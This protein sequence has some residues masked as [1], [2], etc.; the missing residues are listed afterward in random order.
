[1]PRRAA[2][3][4]LLLFV[5]SKSIAQN[6]R[7]DQI[8]IQPKRDVNLSSLRRFQA[9]VGSEVTRTF[10]KFGRL[11]IV[12]VPKGEAA[13]G[14]VE[15]YRRSG[16]VEFAEPDFFGHVFLTP[17]DPK[18]VDH[19][20][21]G[22]DKISAPAAWD[23]QNTASNII[24]AVVD[25]GVRYTHE[26][27]AANMW[28]NPNDGSHGWNALSGTSDPSDDNGHGTMVAG[29]LGAVGNNL[30]GVVGVAW[31]VQIMA[32]KCFDNFGIGSIS[33]VLIGLDYA[34]TNGAK[35]INASW[36]FT[37]SLSLSNAIYSLRDSGI[38]VVAACGNSG[39]NI[40]LS[41]TYPAS[42]HFDN[43]VSVAYTT[44]TDTLAS[45]SNFGATSVHLAAPGDQIYS[46]FSATDNFYYTLSGTSFAAPYVSGTFALMMTKFA[47][48]NY[49]QLI[50][51]VLNA[52]DP[53][54]SLAGKCITGG[55][56][57]VRNAV[58]PPLSLG[59]I[60]NAPFQLHLSGGPNRSCVIESSTNLANWVSVFT[61][62]T[63]TN[64]TFDFTETQSA[65][66]SRF[67]RASSAP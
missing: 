46:T 14:L 49:Q 4:I 62:V 16:L 25:T 64:G 65:S 60:S 58:S 13:L 54:P 32:C 6:F 18:Y 30:K 22:L 34:R 8:L 47:S 50:N 55:R 67:Y 36:G 38:I 31:R 20:L 12:R 51:R 48:E 37:N 35:I 33:S 21:W 45:D 41:P 23:V 44:H 5:L 66:S 2:I 7:N 11:Q 19:T 63:S 53:L 26:D 56:L 17:N 9:S 27:L 42:Y 40:D 28:S 1:M 15:K 3:S 59:V 57:N 61:N 10:E 39:T 43:V 52:T 24:V 29:V